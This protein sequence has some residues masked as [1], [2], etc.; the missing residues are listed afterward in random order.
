LVQWPDFEDSDKALNIDELILKGSAAKAQEKLGCE[1]LNVDFLVSFCILDQT[2]K[3]SGYVMPRT[4][5]SSY[6]AGKMNR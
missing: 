3:L 2:M 6:T 5:P 1:S 4:E